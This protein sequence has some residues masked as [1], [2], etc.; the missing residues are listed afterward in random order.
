MT[1]KKIAIGL[2]FWIFLILALGS[3]GM[4]FEPSLKSDQTGHLIVGAI[5]GVL[6]ALCVREFR[7]VK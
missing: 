4:G 1:L 7:R 2:A 6:C 5:A 3:F